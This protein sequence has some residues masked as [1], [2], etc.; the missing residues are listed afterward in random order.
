MVGREFEFGCLNDALTKML[1]TGGQVV[2]LRGEAGIGKSRLLREFV[3]KM[4]PSGVRVLIGRCHET[5]QILPLHAWIDALRNDDTVLDAVVLDRLG[6]AA[7]AQLVRVFPELPQSG[8]QPVTAPEQY[9]LLFDALARLLVEL[10]S[11][12]PIVFILEDLHW[13][14]SLSARFLSFLA[15]EFIVCQSFRGEYAA[16]RAG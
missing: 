16:R 5:E 15:G 6:A 3:G 14:D 2:L 9:T 1:D 13:C 11:G 7:S 8:S 10:S 4:I 12:Q